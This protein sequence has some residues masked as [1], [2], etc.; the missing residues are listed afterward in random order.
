MPAALATCSRA[1]L[2]S[3][4]AGCPALRAGLSHRA[5]LLQA[6][7]LGAQPGPHRARAPLRGCRCAR[8]R[9]YTGETAC[10]LHRLTGLFRTGPF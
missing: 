5:L 10:W 3:R 1:P 7:P 4:D 6:R 8:H 2:G 9:L